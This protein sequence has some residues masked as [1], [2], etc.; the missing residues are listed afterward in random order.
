MNRFWESRLRLKS[1]RV[2][3]ALRWASTWKFCVLGLGGL[4]LASSLFAA[5]AADEAPIPADV[6]AATEPVPA[7]ELAKPKSSELDDLSLEDLMKVQVSTVSRVDEKI[8]DAPGSV[9]LFPRRVIQDRGYRSLGELLQTVPGFTVFHRDLDFV[10]GVRGLNANDN[11]KVSLLVNGQ[12]VLGLH[13][14]DFLNGPINLDN[15]ERVELVVGPSSFFQQANTLAATI[16]V[17]TKDVEGTELVGAVGNALPYSA[18]LMAGKRWAPDKSASFSLTTE[19]KKGF[20]AWNATRWPNLAGRNLTGELDQ[21]N[22]FGILKGQRG[23]TSGQIVAYKSSWP[24]LNINSGSLNN[25]GKM[26]EQHYS[27]FLK[28]EH[29]SS[30]TLTRVVRLEAALKEQTRLNDGGPP[31]DAVQQSVKQWAYKGEVGL[32]YTGFARHVVQVGIQGSYDHNF[33]T[34]FTFLAPSQP[35]SIPRTT[36]VD[37]DTHAYGIYA[38]DTV[39]VNK[40]L[41][42]IGGLRV[43]QNTRFKG[44]RW[45]LG[46]RSAL[47]YQTK[48][49]WVSKLIYNRSV[50]VPS[51]L[52]AL[53][54]VWGADHLNNPNNPP[55]AQISSQPQNP[56]ILSTIELQNVFYLGGVRLGTTIYYQ[57]LKDFISWFAPHS[58][59]GNFSGPGAELSIQAPLNPRLTIWANGAWNN[60]KLKLF[61]PELFGPGSG[62]VE[63]HHSYINREGRIIG[64]AEYTANLGCDYKVS[65]NLTFSPG[66]RYFTNQAAVEFRPNDQSVFTTIRNRYYLDAALTWHNVRGR[67]MDLRLSARNLLGNRNPVGSQINGDTYRPRGR[68]I[69]LSLD[70]R[71]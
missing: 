41:K 49:N 71:F 9:Y 19:R 34:F 5:R 20:D 27:A 64:S 43:D 60:S 36:L 63:A 25:R 8:D 18:T 69:V 37:Q 66:V 44:N 14:Q 57:R 21:P 70:R 33:D 38:D 2:C 32:R 24:E 29:A 65:D 46:G 61:R 35:G 10:V 16:N 39:Q 28:N 62:G 13:E 68:E 7:T 11:D 48:P 53:N 50:R 26:T 67:D 51:A 4:C 42:F 31:I 45:F 47:I 3:R 58:N 17:I 56:E 55:F 59:G 52:A 6:P 12:L 30:S 23:E 1:Q 15:V 40:R 54:E 22:F